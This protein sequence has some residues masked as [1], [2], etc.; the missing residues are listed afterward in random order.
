MKTEVIVN[1]LQLM[2]LGGMARALER[3]SA[4]PDLLQMSF[5]ERIR[6][7]IEEEETLRRDKRYQ[8]K[9]R[10]AKLKEGAACLEDIDYKS[11]RDLKK[12]VVLELSSCDWVRRKQNICIVGPTGIGKTYLCCALGQRA[13]IEGFSV[14]YVRVPRFLQEMSYA[15]GDGS[16]LQKIGALNKIDLLILDDWGLATLK[17]PERH[18]FLEVIEDRHGVRSTIVASQ[19]PLENWFDLIGEPTIADAIMDRLVNS[20]HKLLMKGPSQRRKRSELTADVQE[21]KKRE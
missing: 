19:H 17:D 12:Q 6:L 15:H 5:D 16:Y 13:C 11:D 2:K 4:S 14:R 18:D 8:A 21:T 10:Q 7:L 1:K 20:S 9:M 3:Q